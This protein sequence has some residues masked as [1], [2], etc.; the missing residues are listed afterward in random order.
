MYIVDCFNENFL[1]MTATYFVICENE[2]I[3]SWVLLSIKEEMRSTNLGTIPFISAHGS[4]FCLVCASCKS[5][6]QREKQIHIAIKCCE[7]NGKEASERYFCAVCKSIVILL[8]FIYS[9]REFWCRAHSMHT[10]L[11]TLHTTPLTNRV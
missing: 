11:H 10:L 7:V 6:K 9:T 8:P 1:I 5:R 4:T 3:I 2:F